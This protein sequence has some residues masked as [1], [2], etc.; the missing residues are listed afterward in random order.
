MKINRKKGYFSISAVA[1]M[2]SI[3][4]QTVRLYEKEGLINPKRS[5]G[6]TRLFSEE[7]VEKLEEVIYLTHELGINLAGVEMI[8]KLKKQIKK[9]QDDMNKIF[10]TTQEQLEKEVNVSKES[11]KESVKRLASIKKTNAHKDNNQH[12]FTPL[13][14]NE[15][16]E[17]KKTLDSENENEEY[18]Q[19]EYEE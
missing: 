10:E 2:F 5:A 13:L 17:D 6:N 8:L 18:W 1:K 3:H 9:M 19:I 12:P 15:S 16:N 14:L 11:V 7:D 4:Q